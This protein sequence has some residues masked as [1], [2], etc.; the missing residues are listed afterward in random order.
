MTL[1][2]QFFAKLFSQKSL[3]EHFGFEL[4]GKAKVPNSKLIIMECFEIRKIID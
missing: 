2:I 3:Y 4:V 1:G